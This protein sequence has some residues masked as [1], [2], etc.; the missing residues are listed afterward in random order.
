MDSDSS[1]SSSNETTEVLGA[2]PYSFEPCTAAGGAVNFSPDVVD[3][4]VRQR[5]VVEV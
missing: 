3:G 5:L 1:S 2:T 4:D